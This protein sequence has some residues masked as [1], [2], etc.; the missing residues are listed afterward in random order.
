MNKGRATWRSL[1]G[2]YRFARIAREP[3]DLIRNGRTRWDRSR[4]V[5]SRSNGPQCKVQRSGVPVAGIAPT[6]VAPSPTLSS[7]ANRKKNGGGLLTNRCV[8]TRRS[9]WRGTG[10]SGGPLLPL[11]ACRSRTADGGI[12]SWTVA[13]IWSTR[14]DKSEPVRCARE[15]GIAEGGWKML[16]GAALTG[17]G[18]FAAAAMARCQARVWATWGCRG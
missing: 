10:C 18:S 16:G 1:I 6:T 2:P 4:S 11:V 8:T 15:Q 13:S 9:R 14:R 17:M 7:T 3:S 5:G 12:G